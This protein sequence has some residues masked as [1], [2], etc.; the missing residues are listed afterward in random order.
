MAH[1]DPGNITCDIQMQTRLARL[2]GHHLP[3]VVVCGAYSHG[4]SSLLNSCMAEDIFEVSDR[5]ETR[6]VQEHVADG[7]C[8]IDTPGLYA[9]INGN[10]DQQALAALDRA[11]HLLLVHRVSTGELDAQ[12]QSGFSEILAAF[13]GRCT[14]VLTGLDEV[15]ESSLAKAIDRV[16][17]QLPEAR[18]LSVSANRYR[19]GCL[20]QKQTL[21]NR[22]NMPALLRHIKE[23]LAFAIAARPEEKARLIAALDR[24]AS[25]KI[26]RCTALQRRSAKQIARNYLDYELEILRF[27][28]RLL[29]KFVNNL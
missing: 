25:Q 8:W 6:A 3:S 10:H 28:S 26:E 11:D 7:I 5:V 22:S 20:E 24:E 12:E 19:K 16:G 21:I 1:I 27:Q 15:D 9:D 13:P 29:R 4:K 23:R 17:T 2:C 14:L 18:V